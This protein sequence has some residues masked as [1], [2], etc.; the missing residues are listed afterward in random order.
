MVAGAFLYSGE[1]MYSENESDASAG[2]KLAVK[3]PGGSN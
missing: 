1:S 3:K 2:I